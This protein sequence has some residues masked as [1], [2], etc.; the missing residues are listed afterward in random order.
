MN[1]CAC[2][3]IGLARDLD[4]YRNMQALHRC[5]RMQTPIESTLRPSHRRPIHTSQCGKFLSQA[6]APLQDITSTPPHVAADPRAVQVQ[7][8]V[9]S[10]SCPFQGFFPFSVFP[11]ARSDISPVIP[12]PLV[13]LRPQGFAPSRR[14]APRTICRAYSIPV[15]LLGFPSEVLILPQ[16]RTFFRT[17]GPS[18][19]FIHPKVN[20]PPQGFSTL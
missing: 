18:E 2:V 10:A 13:K 8:G 11:T 14:F 5:R 7:L 6:L 20:V 16:R 17:P 4:R 19:V 9:G 12:K 15:P 3:P 1:D